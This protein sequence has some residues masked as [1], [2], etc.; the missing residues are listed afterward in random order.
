MIYLE[1]LGY[2]TLLECPNLESITC[3]DNESLEKN[4]PY[5]AI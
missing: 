1:K 5:E 2:A 4:D 3:Y